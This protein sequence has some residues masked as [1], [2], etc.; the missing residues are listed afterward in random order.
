MIIFTSGFPYSGKSTFVQI[1]LENLSNSDISLDKPILL[2][3]KSL[4]PE[5]YE[6]L[7]KDEQSQYNISSWEV[8]IEEAYRTL[9]D[10]DNKTLIILD[11]AAAKLQRMRPL[12]ALAHK[13]RHTIIYA[14]VHSNFEERQSR[15]SNDLSEYENDYAGSFKV[16]MPHLKRF[17]HKFMI[18]RNPNDAE[19]I[20]LKKSSGLVVKIIEETLSD[21][22]W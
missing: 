16:A 7:N 17:A 14:Y 3:P 12:F 1:L 10:K 21:E 2:D 13:K 4:L 19:Y 5:N 8:C 22:N 6:K 18:I 20:D 11:T 15:T 9:V